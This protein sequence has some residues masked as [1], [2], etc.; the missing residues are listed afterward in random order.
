MTYHYNLGLFFKSVHAAYPDNIC[1]KFQDQNFTYKQIGNDADSM[2]SLLLSQGLIRGD[3]IAIINSKEYFSYVMML[4]CLKIGVIYTNIDPD[5]PVER[6]NNI[7]QI[8]CPKRIFIDHSCPEKLLGNAKLSKILIED[9]NILQNNDPLDHS[10]LNN[11]CRNVDGDAIAYI[12]FTSGSTGKPKGV[13]ITHQNLIHFIQWGIKHYSVTPGDIFTNIN[14]MYFDNSVFD[15]YMAMLSGACLVPVKKAIVAA[16]DLLIKYIEDMGCTIWFSVPSLLIYLMSMRVLKAAS[17]SK[18]RLV[19]F[20]GE[21][22]PKIELK[23]IYDL[24]STRILFFNVYGPTECTC[25]CSS[26]QITAADF[27]DLTILAPLGHL[28]PNF[29]YLIFDT[30]GDLAPEGELCLFGPNVGRGYYNDSSQTNLS[31]CEYTNDGYYRS[32]MYRTG[33]IVV[34][35]DNLLHFLGRKDNQ[36]KHMGYRIE[37]EEIEIA[38]GMVPGVNQVAVL[39]EKASTA[40]GKIIAYVASLE[41]IDPNFI[42]QHVQD[43]LPAYMVPNKIMV[44]DHLPK[45]PNGKVDKSALKLRDNE[46]IKV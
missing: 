22:Y 40:Y 38:I 18:L 21:G 42:R 43:V 5:V 12:M 9:I 30:N 26:Y 45:S 4:A 10:R 41:K 37:L 28:N 2:A 27:N 29:S 24:Y 34:L 17:L 19:C 35:K 44:L 25:I 46:I 20:G 8:C 14:P 7:V 23:K 6:F 1:L 11:V 32:R 36:I 33:D 13:A 3:V 16:P 31:F 15:F 39:Y